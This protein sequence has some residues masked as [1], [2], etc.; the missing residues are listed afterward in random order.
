MSSV[1]PLPQPQPT[2]SAPPAPSDL[3]ISAPSAITMTDVEVW[4]TFFDHDNHVPGEY[5]VFLSPRAPIMRLR[6]TIKA[7]AEVYGGLIVGAKI[8]NIEVWKIKSSRLN[9]RVKGLTELVNELFGNLTFTG[10]ED[11]DVELLDQRSKIE[12]L[13]LEDTEPLVVR[14]LRNKSEQ[15]LFLR[16]M[17]PTELSFIL[18][19]QTRSR[20][21]LPRRCKRIEISAYWP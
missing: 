16:I 9:P 2:P 18:N 5:T 11:C 17:F 4:F 12:D 7:N 3:P 8:S 6:N 14:V 13:R 20:G 21:R 19:S 1:Q 15:L 10:D